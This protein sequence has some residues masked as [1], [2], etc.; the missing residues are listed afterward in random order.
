MYHTK[1]AGIQF[2]NSVVHI[3]GSA[4]FE[5]NVDGLGFPNDMI[6]LMQNIISIL[7]P[8]HL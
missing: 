8:F 5:N 1:L 7:K 3:S 2:N 6:I 4:P